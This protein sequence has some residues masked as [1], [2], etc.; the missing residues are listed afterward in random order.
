MKKGRGVNVQPSS[1]PDIYDLPLQEL[2]ESVDPI[3]KKK[4]FNPLRIELD[5]A[6]PVVKMEDLC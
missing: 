6:T 2:D 5:S 1:S 4:A 3:N